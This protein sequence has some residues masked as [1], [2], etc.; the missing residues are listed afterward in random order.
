MLL[1]DFVNNLLGVTC[2]DCDLDCYK[3]IYTTKCPCKACKVCVEGLQD[4]ECKWTKWKSFDYYKDTVEFA[5]FSKTGYEYIGNVTP[6]E[7][8]FLQV[9]AQ[10]IRADGHNKDNVYTYGTHELLDKWALETFPDVK[11]QDVRVQMQEPGQKVDPHV[12]TLVGHLKNWMAIDPSLAELNHSMA[13][14]APELKAVRYF[15]ACEDHVEGQNFMF[16]NKPWVWKKGDVVSLD[17]HRG[18][19]NTFN[20]SDKDRY[21]IKLTGRYLPSN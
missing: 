7:L 8:S 19:H 2:S 15:I 6:P 4:E 9:I 17:V 5:D 16:N 14:P 3:A 12:D 18:M 1:K 20:E 11:F 10:D 13:E 21:I